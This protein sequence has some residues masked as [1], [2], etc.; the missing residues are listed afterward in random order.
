MNLREYQRRLYDDILSAFDASKKPIN[1]L[2]TCA[3]GGGKTV[4]FSTVIFEYLNRGKWVCAIAHRQELV[5]QISI[6]LARNGVRHQLIGDKAGKL[7]RLAVWAHIQETG[8]NYIDPSSRCIVIGVKTLLSRKD[9]LKYMLDRIGLWVMDEAHHVL[10][11]NEWGKAVALMPRAY[12]LGV[13][14]TAG[15]ADGKGLGRSSDGVFDELITGPDTGLLMREGW[16][17]NYEIVCPDSKLDL[18]GVAVS[19]ATGDYV[20]PQLRKALEKSEIIGD[21][22]DA[23]QEFVPGKLC[24]V[25][26]THKKI[27]METAARFQAAGIPAE[28]VHDKTPDSIRLNVKQR[29]KARELLVLI[30]VDLFGEGVDLPS[31]EAVI[32][33]RPTE[34]LPLYLQQCG[35][36]F[37]LLLNEGIDETSAKRRLEQIAQSDKPIGWII[38]LVGNYIR[39]LPPDMHREWSLAPRVKRTKNDT[40]MVP[41]VNCVFCLK[42]YPKAKSFCPWCKRGKPTPVERNA[43]EFVE[44][45]L[46]LLDDET[47]AFLMREKDRV[48][49]SDSEY[50]RQLIGRRVPSIGRT[51]MLRLHY[52][53]QQAQKALRAVMQLWAERNAAEVDDTD[54]LQRVFW[55]RFGV[56]VLSA[57]SLKTTDAWT[58]SARVSIDIGK[59]N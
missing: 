50:E 41:L 57:Q 27:G 4:I 51:R 12:G 24:V 58:L 36:L 20:E 52:E 55:Y 35:R 34:S 11:V 22:V 54:E 18:A 53:Q 42:P 30:N 6:S 47:R 28:F 56:D 49:V 39:H 19:K 8:Q 45:A 2:A 40:G 25:F 3:T 15:R 7:Q 26:V 10:R 37:R 16:L 5:I 46:S 38:D 1:V 48:D 43:P 59:G 44:G 29:F 21:I 31:M 14:A 33:A 17:T 32:F 9:R 23:Y 13:T